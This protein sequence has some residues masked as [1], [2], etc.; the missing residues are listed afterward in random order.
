MHLKEV[1]IPAG[2]EKYGGL[3]LTQP[4]MASKATE[5]LAKLKAGTLIDQAKGYYDTMGIEVPDFNM[6]DKVQKLNALNEYRESFEKNKTAFKAALVKQKEAA[7]KAQKAA[8]AKAKPS[9][10]PDQTTPPN[11]TK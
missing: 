7:V 4:G 2:P 10:S 9:S 5:A 11:A 6:M 3:K 1:I 8:E